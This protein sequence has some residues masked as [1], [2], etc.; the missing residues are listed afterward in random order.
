MRAIARARH[1]TTPPVPP[2]LAEWP[3]ILNS[4]EWGSRLANCNGTEYRFF[5]GPLEVLGEDGNIQFVGVV[6]CNNQFL[7]QMNVY[8][9]SVRTLCINGTFQVRPAYPPDVAQLL[10]VQ[11]VF[12]NVA[13]PII[14][15]LLINN[16]TTAYCRVMQFIRNDLAL[17]L[18]YE[19]LQIIT[20]YEHGLRNAI[21]RV[22]PEATNTGCW[23][24]YIRCITRYLRNNGLINICNTNENARCIVRMLMALPHLPGNPIEYHQNRFSIQLGFRFIQDL[25]RDYELEVQLGGLLRYFERFWMDVVGPLNFTV[26]RLRYRANNFIESYH[27]TLVRLMGQHP[28]LYRFYEHLRGIEERSRADFIRAINGQPVRRVDYRGNTRPRN[29]IIINTAWERCENGVYNLENFIRNVSHTPEQLLRNEI[30]E[31]NFIERPVVLPVAQIQP[32]APPPPL[33]ARPQPQ[34]VEPQPLAPAPRQIL[35]HPRPVAIRQPIRPPPPVIQPRQAVQPIPLE[36]R[37]YAPQPGLDHRQEVDVR[38]A[39]DEF[40]QDIEDDDT[41]EPENCI[42]CFDRLA[43]VTLMPCRHEFC[44]VC[45]TRLVADQNRRC[46]LCRGVIQVYLNYDH[47]M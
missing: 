5:Q 10:T 41:E 40:L 28:P 24:H 38:V 44:N 22:I 6:F 25:V 19:N 45:V 33:S 14:H 23:F 20:D 26:Y 16:T 35:P 9:P 37:G 13:I 7:H 8:M 46:P 42:I 34:Q 4:A 29:D 30:G 3:A 12:N 47:P 18:S 2:S 32:L 21:T 1:R 43:S 11:I 31:P 39:W 15:V 27:A 36:Q 17:N